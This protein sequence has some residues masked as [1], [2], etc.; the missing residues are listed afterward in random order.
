MGD[1]LAYSAT[2]LIGLGTSFLILAGRR[3]DRIARGVPPSWA[4]AA[5]A[6][7]VVV[8]SVVA[9]L[10][11]MG[12]TWNVEGTS[13]RL[14]FEPTGGLRATAALIVLTA[15]LA[16]PLVVRRRIVALV[17]GWLTLAFSFVTGFSIG[18]LYVPVACLLFLGAALHTA[19]SD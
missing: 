5:L 12:P 3:G 18:L 4:T 19:H 17:A 14:V 7:A 8:A 2:F 10:I 11:L 6:G 15:L 9:V 1:V 13:R 16:I